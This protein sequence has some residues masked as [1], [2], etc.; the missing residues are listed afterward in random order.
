LVRAIRESTS[1]G[2]ELVAFILRVFRGRLP[3]VRLQ[4][5]IE[6]ATWLAD[7]GFGKPVQG[8]GMLVAA[9]SER[10]PLELLREVLAESDAGQI[11][12]DPG[13]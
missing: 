4:D 6:A 13:V 7:R 1:D 9:E 2:E 11:T 8:V 5:R 10:I 12:R 3:G